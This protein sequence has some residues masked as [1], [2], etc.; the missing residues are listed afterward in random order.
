MALSS[1]SKAN[2]VRLGGVRSFG[3]R[4]GG[5]ERSTVSGGGR[6]GAMEG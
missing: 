5:E 2:A 4:R 1:V 6:G 3:A